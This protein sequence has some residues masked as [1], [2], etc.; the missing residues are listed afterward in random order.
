MKINYKSIIIAACLLIGIIAFPLRASYAVSPVVQSCSAAVNSPTTAQT[1]SCTMSSPV[2]SLNLIVGV[3]TCV[4]CS[5][6]ANPIVNDSH[7]DNYHLLALNT[8]LGAAETSVIGIAN[9]TGSGTM[10]V[11]G[12]IRDSANRTSWLFSAYEVDAS[13]VTDL[14][15]KMIAGIGSGS[16]WTTAELNSPLIWTNSSTLIFEGAD[17]NNLAVG[18]TSGAF[19]TGGSQGVGPANIHCYSASY[20]QSNSP[21]SFTMGSGASSSGSEVVLIIP[22]SIPTTITVTNTITGFLVPNFVNGVNSFSWLYFLIIVFVPMGEIIGMMTVDRGAVLDRHA[23]IFVFLSL[24]LVDSIF[25]VMINLVT[26]AM[27][28]IFGIL[29]AVYLWR[30]RG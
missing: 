18:C 11:S 2:T 8:G 20:A 19:T 28:F 23:L 21:S 15:A 13:Q 9:I 14:T 17:A 24:L 30:G 10:V 1:I 5:S 6:L 22:Y 16:T 25:G 29:F 3:V 12:Q 7:N 27:P 4:G 26:V